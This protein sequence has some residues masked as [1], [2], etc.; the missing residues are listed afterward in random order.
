M[1]MAE[2]MQD[3]IGEEYNGVISGVIPSGIFVRLPNLIEG[4]VHISTLNDYYEFNEKG[5]MLIG[6][7]G[8]KRY[9]LGD[10]VKVKVIQASKEKR[11][12][13]FIMM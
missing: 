6:R 11:T 8:K 13:D 1:K 7:K 5:Q 10:E 2:Y 4:F 9:R 3:H 12:I